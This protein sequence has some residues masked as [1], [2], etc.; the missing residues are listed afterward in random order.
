MAQ[1]PCAIGSEAVHARVDS[2][3]LLP[4][5]NAERNARR[6]GPAAG[7]RQDV[8]GDEARAGRTREPDRVA[9]LGALAE[10]AERDLRRHLGHRLVI[11][12]QLCRAVVGFLDLV[13]AD[14]VDRDAVAAD[15]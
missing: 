2:R 4:E 10:A 8:A 13:R 12:E 7:V 3:G 1:N 15:L 9:E 6:S 14:D 11:G 5:W